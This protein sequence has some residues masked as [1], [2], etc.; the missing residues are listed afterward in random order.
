M[1]RSEIPELV[2]AGVILRRYQN[3]ARARGHRLRTCWASEGEE[4]SGYGDIG[5]EDAESN[6]GDDGQEKNEGHDECGHDQ[7]QSLRIGL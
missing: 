7:I 1:N 6:R 2:A 3:E 5:G 4:D